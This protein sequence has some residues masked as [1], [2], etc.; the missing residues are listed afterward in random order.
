MQKQ[1]TGEVKPVAYVSRYM[2]T[3]EEVRPDQKRSTGFYLGMRA[4]I[5]LPYRT[6][7]SN[8]N[9]PQA[10]RTA[11]QH[12]EP[13]AASTASAMLPTP[14]DEVFIHHHLCPRQGTGDCRH[15][16]SHSSREYHSRREPSPRRN[17]SVCKPDPEEHTCNGAASGRD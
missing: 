10:A 3:T 5:G 17:K 9:R 2:T 15:S 4:P 16:F 8:R 13:G 6:Q 11:F 14:H 7:V 12:E 1:V